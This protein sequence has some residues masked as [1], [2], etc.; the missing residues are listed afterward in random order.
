MSAYLVFISR[1]E[2]DLHKFLVA[3]TVLCDAAHRQ[4][5]AFQQ[6]RFRGVSVTLLLQDGNVLL[7]DLEFGTVAQHGDA[8]QA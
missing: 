1:V 5:N 4:L 2:G 3:A 8:S 7:S 6:G